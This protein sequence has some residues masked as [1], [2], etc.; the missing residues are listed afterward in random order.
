MRV[1]KL[2][3]LLDEFDDDQEICIS[4]KFHDFKDWSVDT[5]DIGWGIHEEDEGL[6]LKVSVYQ[7]DFDYSRIMRELKDIV[8]AIPEWV[9]SPK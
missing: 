1:D 3:R 7:A 2:H 5:Y 4:M 8:E 6:V 9:C